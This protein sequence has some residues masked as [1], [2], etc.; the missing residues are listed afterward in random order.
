M[1]LHALLPAIMHHAFLVARHTT[2]LDARR[3]AVATAPPPPR[4]K[5]A[6]VWVMRALLDGELDQQ[7]ACHPSPYA[8]LRGS[9]GLLILR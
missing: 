9:H 2:G 5:I 3:S 7:D 4:R 6:K 8:G 1:L